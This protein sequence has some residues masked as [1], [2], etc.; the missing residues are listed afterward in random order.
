MCQR[1]VARG[2]RN[3]PLSIYEVGET[4]LIRYPQTKKSVTKRH[5]LEADVERSVRLQKYKVAFIS[6]TTGKLMHKWIPVSDVTS[7]TMEREKQKKNKKWKLSVFCYF[8]FS[9]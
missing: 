7:L 4:V 1:M 5:V 6:P 2:E 3:N 9:K 8:P